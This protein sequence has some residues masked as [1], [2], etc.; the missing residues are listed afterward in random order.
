M[1]QA[2]AQQSAQ[3]FRPAGTTPSPDLIFR[4]ES[5]KRTMSGTMVG[6]GPVS[7][8]FR[9]HGC[10][11]GPVVVALGGISANR[12]VQCWWRSL[13]ASQADAQACL[14]PGRLLILGM[15]WLDHA[16]DPVDGITTANQADALALVLDHLGLDRIDVLI[17]ASY[18]AMVGLSFAQRHHQRTGHLV[19]ISGADRSRPFSTALRHIQRE[20]V[21]FG[22]ETGQGARG[23]ALARAL[24]LTTYRPAGL[25]DQRFGKALPNHALAELTSYFAHAGRSFSEN[26]GPE[27]YQRLS[28][29]L[30]RHH[31]DPGQIRVPVDLVAVDSD[32]LVTPA[33]I[34][35]L[36]RQLGENCRLHTIQSVYGHD[37][38]LKEP[39]LF[40]RLLGE[41]ISQAVSA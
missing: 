33:Q 34:Q 32:Q 27:R 20:I 3:A 18:G 4:D 25:F 2:V 39:E 5:I 36:A 41:L 23:V 12:Q 22:L 35:A 16:G 24:A 29:S 1:N 40:N 21:Q 26:F 31:V 10:P 8:R 28:D 13:Y 15:D 30:D 17:G 14:D 6:A 9:L 38:F 19:A 7:I 11:S 37:A